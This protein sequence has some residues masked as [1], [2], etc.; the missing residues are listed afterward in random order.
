MKTFIVVLLAILIASVAVA[1]Q[2]AQ[3]F[4]GSTKAYVA[5]DIQALVNSGRLSALDAYNG[6]TFSTQSKLGDQ[7]DEW[8]ARDISK[9]PNDPTNLYFTRLHRVSR[10]EL[11]F[12]EC[13][14]RVKRVLVAY[15]LPTPIAGTPG[16]PGA[17]GG[18]GAQGIPGLPG[19]PGGPGT[20]GV[21]G[22]PGTPGAPGQPGANGVTTIVNIQQVEHVVHHTLGVPANYAHNPPPQLA[23]QQAPGTHTTYFPGWLNGGGLSYAE[24]STTTIVTSSLGGNATSASSSAS[25]GGDATGGAGG[26]GGAGGSNGPI[27]IGIANTAV[28]QANPTQTVTQN[29]AQQQNSATAVEAGN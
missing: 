28:S 21:P 24:G 10:G 7:V 2:D 14:N 12:G 18:P 11:V 26:Q 3:M 8:S 29:A 16:T 27:R 22:I 19:T 23:Q 15:H 6:I 4:G 13:G 25:T 5:V 20:Q 1:Q 9:G 17:P